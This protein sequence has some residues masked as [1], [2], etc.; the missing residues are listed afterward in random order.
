M[1]I[2][3][4]RQPAPYIEIKPFHATQTIEECHDNGD[5]TISLNVQHNYELERDILAFGEGM[6][7]LLPNGLRELIARRLFRAGRQYST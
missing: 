4:D 6:E 2:R 3:V 1:L 7:V 5:V